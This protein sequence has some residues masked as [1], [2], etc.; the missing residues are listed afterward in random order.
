MD[1]IIKHTPAPWGVLQYKT[2]TNKIQTLVTAHGNRGHVA[3]LDV[4]SRKP[5]TT[6]ADARLIAAA[7]MLFEAAVKA[8]ELLDDPERTKG[9]E[10]Q[11]LVMLL[12]AIDKAR[13]GT[14]ET[15]GHLPW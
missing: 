12:N 14:Y 13:T 15:E 3:R 1:Q 8:K 4:T 5:E 9:D 2:R 10:M 7:P 11:V 6:L